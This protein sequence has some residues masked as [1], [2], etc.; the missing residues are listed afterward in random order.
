LE[1]GATSPVLN[2]ETVSVSVQQAWPYIPY[3]DRTVN[4]D[5]LTNPLYQFVRAFQT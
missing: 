3:K 4:T 1:G 5:E 2:F